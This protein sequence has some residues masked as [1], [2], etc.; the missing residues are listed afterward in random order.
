MELE[1][2]MLEQGPNMDLIDP[3]IIGSCTAESLTTVIDIA[4]KCLLKDPASRPSMEDVLWNLQY[5]LQV[6]DISNGE[7]QGNVSDRLFPQALP[8]WKDG[9]SERLHV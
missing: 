8:T 4:A 6:Q 7:H 9:D 1:T 3:T 2:L 5:A